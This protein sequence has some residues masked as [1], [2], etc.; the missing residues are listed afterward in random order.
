MCGSWREAAAGQRLLAPSRS[1]KGVTASEPPL[2]VT[3]TL[4]RVLRTDAGPDS[5]TGTSLFPV[6]W[7]QRGRIQ[8]RHILRKPNGRRQGAVL[9]APGRRCPGAGGAGGQARLEARCP[10]GRCP[11]REGSC[12][13]ASARCGR[14]LTRLR[15]AQ[16]CG[17]G[18]PARSPVAISSA[19]TMWQ[20][21]L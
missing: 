9:W 11:L 6:P 5:R 13:A 14:G 12:G 8:T 18:R 21:L 15:G 19:L 16:R 1:G 10:A 4:V 2:A 3:V 7:G 17:A 20:A